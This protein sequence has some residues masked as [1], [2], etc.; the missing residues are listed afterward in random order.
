MSN[1]HNRPWFDKK[2][3]KT[4]RL[5]RA[6]LK[7]FKKESTITNLID[8]KLNRAKA[9]RMIKAVKKNAAKNMLAN[10]IPLL[11]QNRFEK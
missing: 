8:Y 4:I 11:N 2:W 7:K 6:A 3:Q 9:S 10:K 5:H 1:R